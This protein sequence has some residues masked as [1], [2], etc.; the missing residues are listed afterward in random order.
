MS[1][2][3]LH[4]LNLVRGAYLWGCLRAVLALAVEGDADSKRE[5]ETG[6]SVQGEIVFLF[7]TEND[8]SRPVAYLDSLNL[9][10]DEADALFGGRGGTPSLC[11]PPGS[12]PR[13]EVDPRSGKVEASFEAL[14]DFPAVRRHYE[15]REKDLGSD[16][17]GLAGLP[18]K[19][20]LEGRI[21]SERRPVEFGF[22]H[23]EA[24]L[25]IALPM[26]AQEILKISKLIIPV[27][28]PLQWLRLETKREL[29][30][31]PVF[32]AAATGTPPTGADFYP[33]LTR[34]N[35]LWGRCCVEFVAKC[36]MYVDEQD[37]RVATEAE[38]RDFK[39]SRDVSDAVEVFIVEELDPV[40]LWGGGATFGSG[41]AAAK[42]VSTD[43][44]LP[45]NQNHLAH[46]LGHVLGLGHPGDTT[47]SLVDGC[48]GSVMEPSGFFADNPGVQCEDNCQ[49]ASNPH[50]RLRP[51]KYCLSVDRPDTQ[52]F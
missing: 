50:L 7:G 19:V 22:E 13:V 43:N 16:T 9:V 29:T 14:V 26:Q 49:N 47:D 38:A 18:A 32:L 48:V 8:P 40:D 17:P 41:T 20:Q 12:R 44:Q 31:Q 39:D 36:P 2:N 33:G 25:S 45:L 46:E 51:G 23:L 28:T 52:L 42:V 5:R 15:G 4:R 21:P 11:L 35:E 30:V 24:E 3:L 27:V 10:F 37:W 6:P 34:A 1:H